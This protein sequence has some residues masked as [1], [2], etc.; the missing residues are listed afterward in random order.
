MLEGVAPGGV[1]RYAGEERKDDMRNRKTLMVLGAGL[2]QIPL[3]RRARDLGHRVIT[4]DNIPGNIGHKIADSSLNISTAD[5]NGVLR[6]AGEAAVDGLLTYGSD[7]AVPTVAAVTSMLGLVGPTRD[8][9][10]VMTNKSAFRAFQSGTARPSPRY[11]A[12]ADVEQGLE[13]SRHLCRPFVA[14]PVDTSGSRGISLVSPADN[15]DRA[16]GAISAALSF[17]R[18]GT[19]CL[20]EFVE[21]VHSSGDVFLRNGRIVGGGITRQYLK[22]FAVLG[23]EMP[24][25]MGPEC[26]DRIK[27]EVERT[28]GLIGYTDGPLD[29]DVVSSDKHVTIIELSPRLGGNG[30]PELVEAATGFELIT[31]TIRWALGEQAVDLPGPPPPGA[32]GSVILRSE[33][34]GVLSGMEPADSVRIRIPELIH[35]YYGV[36]PGDRIAAFEHGG[37]SLGYG[38]F[39]IPNGESHSSVAGRIAAALRLQIAAE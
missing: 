5:V 8:A 10:S 32:Y 11:F 12:C 25:G 19:A 34:L 35:L 2:Y 1:A 39:T 6:A 9:A 18:A 17:S 3:I 37:H 29:F 24:S 27:L 28:C 15:D 21:G 26:E 33:Q 31:T 16:R 30:M 4:V 20:E 14:K 36:R 23:H 7:V 22:G 13:G 38:L